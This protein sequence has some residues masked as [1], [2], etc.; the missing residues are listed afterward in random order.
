METHQLCNPQE[1]QGFPFLAKPPSATPYRR[2]G[3]QPTYGE[4]PTIDGRGDPYGGG[5][6]WEGEATGAGNRGVDCDEGRGAGRGSMTEAAGDGDSQR[7]GGVINGKSGS[8]WGG[9]ACETEPERDEYGGGSGASG[10]TN[11]GGSEGSEADS[12][13]G[14]V[15]HQTCTGGTIEECQ[16]SVGGESYLPTRGRSVTVVRAP[17]RGPTAARRR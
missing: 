17:T 1:W 16:N 4:G 14:V 2:C 5:R 13:R 11:E 8:S 9:R 7:G 3:R 10:A 15:L 12:S 6:P